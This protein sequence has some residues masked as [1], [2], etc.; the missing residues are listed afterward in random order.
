MSHA[1][2]PRLL[3]LVLV[4]A[5]GWPI[6]ESDARG[7]SGGSFSSSSRSSSSF[8]RPS[9]SPSRSYSSS[10]STSPSSN[11]FAPSNADSSFST[12]VNRSGTTSSRDDFVRQQEASTSA[13]RN[14]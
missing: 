10:P 9:S 5:V 7:K 2:F 1:F 6:Q 13:A 12:K 14:A 8:S 11:R 4:L 3:A